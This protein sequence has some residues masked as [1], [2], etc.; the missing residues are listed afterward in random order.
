MERPWPDLG[1][2]QIS[3]EEGEACKREE[4]TGAGQVGQ[5]WGTDV[6]D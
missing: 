6:E 5:M 3:R 1:Q 4:I 2:I